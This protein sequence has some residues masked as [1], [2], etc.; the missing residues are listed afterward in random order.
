MS[1]MSDIIR[2]RR[3]ELGI[4]QK[5][6]ADM[7][8]ISDKTVSRWESS[9][10]MPDAILLPDLAEALNMSIN[11][12]YGLKPDGKAEGI[13]SPENFYPKVKS[14]VLTGYKI[15]LMV[16]LMFFV[17]G[18]VL[19]IHFNAFNVVQGEDRYFGKIFLYAGCVMCIAFEIAYII[20][21][22]NKHFYNPL[23]LSE[24]IKYGGLCAMCI[25]IVTMEVFPLFLAVHVSYWY[26]LVTVMFLIAFEVMLISQK[27][28]LRK[29]GIEIGKKISVISI[30]VISACVIVM[31]GVFV[32]FEFFYVCDLEQWVQ[33]IV[34]LS[35]GETP[36]ESKVRLYSYMLLSIPMILALLMNYIQLLIKS[37]KLSYQ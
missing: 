20:F 15:A 1:T 26:E 4:T 27:R 3:K 9:N 22:R 36:F 10:Q 24:D 30:T 37:K 34:E 25:S 6:L 8:S 11:E 35:G 23:Y 32:Y 7:L 33:M 29:S 31:I 18:A 13:A 19:Q 2:E 28:E 12:L 17:F 14:W 5:E 16:G 21:Y